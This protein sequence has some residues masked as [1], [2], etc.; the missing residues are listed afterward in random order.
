MQHRPRR[1]ARR[2]SGDRPA[3]RAGRGHPGRAAQPARSRLFPEMFDIFAAAR[4]A[5]AARLDL[6]ISGG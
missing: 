3:G 2:R 5:G 4:A 6:G 1:A